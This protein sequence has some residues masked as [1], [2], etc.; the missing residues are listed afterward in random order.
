MSEDTALTPNELARRIENIVRLGTVAQVDHANAL[1]RV[2]SGALLTAWLPWLEQRAGNVRTWCPPSVGEQALVLAPSGD[3]AA[4]WVM[5]GGP[6]EA[7]PAPSTSPNVHRTQYP[8]GTVI[9]YDHQSHA[10]TISLGSGTQTINGQKVT[11]NADFEVNGASTLNGA[12]AVYGPTLTHNDVN[13]GDDH[14]HAGSPSAP[15]GPPSPTGS[16]LS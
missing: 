15:P 16:P 4:G 8:D 11:F 3:L 1:V 9:D 6:S 5:V 13:V 10:L 12:T 2:K 7:H 14:A